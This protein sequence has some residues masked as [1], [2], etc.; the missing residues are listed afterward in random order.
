M[1]SPFAYSSN[2]QSVYY[3]GKIFG[4]VGS[5]LPTT[6]GTIFSALFQTLNSTVLVLGA[7]LVVYT[8]VIGLLKTAQEGEFLGKQWNSLWVP[9]RTVMGIASLFPTGT[10]YSVLQVIFMWVIVQGIGAADTLWNSALNFISRTGSPYATVSGSSAG[11][12]GI[13]TNLETLFQAMVCQAS[14]AANYNDVSY[15]VVS[16]GT[17]QYF[18]CAANSNNAFCKR[19]MWYGLL[20]IIDGPQTHTANGFTS[21]SIGPN[22]SSP[23][24]DGACGVMSYKDPN[25]FA[26]SSLPDQTTPVCKQTSDAAVLECKSI[27]TQQQ[28]LQSIVHLYGEMGR[29]LAELDYDYILFYED[30]TVPASG[31]GF[32]FLQNY[33]T[34]ATTASPSGLGYTN[35]GQ[36]C[37][38]SS[39]TGRGLQNTSCA[40]RGAQ[41]G[42]GQI[43]S[44]SSSSGS[45]TSGSA[46]STPAST[47]DNPFPPDYVTQ[48]G[49]TDYTN[50]SKEAIKL[51]WNFAVVPGDQQVLVNGSIITAMAKYYTD[52]LSAAVGTAGVATINQ[53]AGSVAAGFGQSSGPPPGFE[54]QS[55]VGWILAGS[56]YFTLAKQSNASLSATIPNSLSVVGNDPTYPSDQNAPTLPAPYRNNY[57]AVGHLVGM[58]AS[59]NPASQVPSQVGNLSNSLGGASTGLMKTYMTM[60]TGGQGG[61]PI[62]ALQQFGESML[63][64]AQVIY[65]VILV[66]FPLISSLVSIDFLFMGTGLTENPVKSGWFEFATLVQPLFFVLCGFLFTFGGILGIYTPLIPYTVYTF[67]AIGWLSGV[68]EAMAAAPF[69]ALG[70]LCPGGQH[71]ILGR[72]EPAIG[73]LLN[74]FVR[75]MLMVFGMM[76]AMILAPQV[77]SLINAGFMNVMGSMGNGVP[78]PVEMIFFMVIYTSIVI[79]ALNKCF[80]LIYLIPERVLTWIGMQGVN[81]G[82]AESLQAVKG[83]MEAAG[84]AI[85]AGSKSAAETVK[86][87]SVKHAERRKKADK[88]GG[89]G[90]SIGGGT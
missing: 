21:Y 88:G 3:L 30:N 74:L 20:N 10:G 49:N 7:V 36:C 35:P 22:A 80:A 81:Y 67:S 14:L 6:D 45:A 39:S 23:G 52:T 64:T 24:S 33:C 32:Y 5:V 76:A 9:L 1:I 46:T 82:E 18:F 54:T 43:S 56:Y 26:D 27:K 12:L 17:Q 65:P 8:T 63:I 85:S 77:V 78:G 55:A 57:S 60:L 84:E 4:A 61:D 34:A 41:P 42:A 11:A 70:I 68:M 25:T 66:A 53:S 50:T 48:N 16:G 69:V 79:T 44:S 15:N 29:L 47:S 75:P 86:T 38:Y 89:G 71:E 72:A 28:I 31:T 19:E 37:V 13:T 90:A 59:A 83:S 73:I 40:D 2:D 51:L 62:V 87:G 58:N